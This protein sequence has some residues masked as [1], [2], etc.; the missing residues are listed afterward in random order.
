VS[1]S[2][3]EVRWRAETTTV[4]SGT[5]GT[6]NGAH[7]NGTHTNGTAEAAVPEG[8]TEVEDANVGG[9]PDAAPRPTGEI[10]LE[11]VVPPKKKRWFSRRNK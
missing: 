1:A 5:N 11:V 3:Q 7:T 8:S 4:G 2:V 6:Q 10:D 9:E